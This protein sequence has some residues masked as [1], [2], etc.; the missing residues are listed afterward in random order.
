MFDEDKVN[1]LDKWIQNWEKT[2]GENPITNEYITRFE[3]KFDQQYKEKE[4]SYSDKDSITTYLEIFPSLIISNK[5]RGKL[6]SY[7]P[8]HK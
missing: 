3:Q 8:I 2:Y 6:E 7:L 4:F 5:L 1:F